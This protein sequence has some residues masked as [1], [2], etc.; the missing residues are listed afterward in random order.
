MM[1]KKKKEIKLI[2]EYG[3]TK[4]VPDI[5]ETLKEVVDEMMVQYNKKESKK[6]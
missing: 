2:A 3:F 6:E 1:K 5:K 4:E